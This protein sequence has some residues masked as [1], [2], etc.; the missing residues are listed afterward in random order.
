MHLLLHETANSSAGRDQYCKHTE[1]NG[2]KE[3]KE[4]TLRS[5]ALKGMHSTG[6]ILLSTHRWLIL[7]TIKAFFCPYSYVHGRDLAIWLLPSW[8]CYVNTALSCWSLKLVWLSSF[9]VF[10]SPKGSSEYKRCMGKYFCLPAE[11]VFSFHS[12]H[13]NTCFDQ[14]TLLNGKS[15]AG[16]PPKKTEQFSFILFPSFK[17]DFYFNFASRA[18]CRQQSYRRQFLIQRKKS[19]FCPLPW[20]KEWNQVLPVSLNCSAFF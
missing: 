16:T 15:T 7:K 10:P 3:R 2:E 5:P 14:S 6:N 19:V 1:P 4:I 12:V 9:S 18:A 20:M 13:R 8:Q 11:T 17:L